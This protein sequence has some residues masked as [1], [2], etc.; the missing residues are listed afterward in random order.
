MA[1]KRYLPKRVNKKDFKRNATPKASSVL[2]RHLMRGGTRE[3]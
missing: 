1:R 3:L 2:G